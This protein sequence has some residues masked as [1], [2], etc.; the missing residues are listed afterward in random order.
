M[1]KA[2]MPFRMLLVLKE[3]TS[4]SSASLEILWIE[5]LQSSV[6]DVQA[7]LCDYAGLTSS[8]LLTFTTRIFVFYQTKLNFI[9]YLPFLLIPVAT[10]CSLPG[11]N[12]LNNNGIEIQ[13]C[14]LHISMLLLWGSNRQHPLCYMSA[15]MLE[16]I[17]SMAD[18][19]KHIITMNV[20][21]TVLNE[22]ISLSTTFYIAVTS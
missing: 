3:Q 17:W 10:Q 16:L 15:G 7:V 19:L 14:T 4:P 8:I 18:F 12:R 13:L 6:T 11:V 9:S 21:K 5:S 2:Q 1:Q 22:H 20:W